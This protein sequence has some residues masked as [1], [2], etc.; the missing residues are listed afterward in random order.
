MSFYKPGNQELSLLDFELLQLTKGESLEWVSNDFEV[1][2]VIIEGECSVSSEMQTWKL[3]RQTVFKDAASAVFASPGVKLS[4][5]ANE[6]TTLAMCKARAEK[7]FQ[8]TFIPPENVNS[9]WRGREGYRRRVSNILNT[10]TQT[11]RIAVGETINE[12]GQWSSFPS[13]KHDTYEKSGDRTVE[14]PLEEIY[15]FRLEPKTGFGLQRLYTKDG[16]FDE[17][18]VIKD[19]DVV[20]IPKGYHPVAS[21]P[22]HSLYYLWML[23][24]ENR[25]YIWNTDPGLRWLERNGN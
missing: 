7:R 24:G 17:A 4:I 19:G 15:Y 2:A 1:V 13:H 8:T 25:V 10:E 6:K 5:I 14:V 21:I 12:P 18:R 20:Q 16:S 23:G 9:E 3:S 22:G 11:Q